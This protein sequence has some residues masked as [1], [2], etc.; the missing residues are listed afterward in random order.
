MDDVSCQTDHKDSGTLCSVVV[1][2]CVVSVI[3]FL[4]LAFKIRLQV[5]S[6]YF[7]VIYNL[8]LYTVKKK[9]GLKMVKILA[10]SADV[11]NVR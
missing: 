5:K 8:S 2:T 4:K 1:W 10:G 9:N 6:A 7:S 3:P 11:N